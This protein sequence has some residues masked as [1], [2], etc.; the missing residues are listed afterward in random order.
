MSERKI[1]TVILMRDGTPRSIDVVLC[2]VRRMSM[3][4][5]EGR[6]VV[7]APKTTT[8]VEVRDFVLRHERWLRA[9]SD[10]EKDEKE[11]IHI[12]GKS[13]FVRIQEGKNGVDIAGDE[14]VVCAPDGK[15]ATA[16]Q[17]LKKWYREQA[18][19][20][21]TER[22]KELFSLA[23]PYVGIKSVPKVLVYYVTTYWGKCFY[24]RSEIRYN[25]YLY[26]AEPSVID[27]VICHEFAHFKVHDHSE[28]FYRVL[29]QY[30]PAYKEER[31]KLKRYPTKAFFD[32][33][34]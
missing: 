3:R 1:S 11:G 34:G 29:S 28:R 15:R 10:Q 17:V 2:D 7:R 19:A 25:A 14:I 8:P 24:Q 16:K 20:Y 18:K 32:D 6:I 5:D 21:L 27:Y 31:N 33:E 13:Y 4:V 9:R 23:A 26:R 22:T 30:F 12:L